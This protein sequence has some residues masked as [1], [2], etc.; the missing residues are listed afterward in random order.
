[1]RGWYTDEDIEEMGRAT[2]WTGTILFAC[3]GVLGVLG[4]V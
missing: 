4:Y 2:V 1:V 3:L